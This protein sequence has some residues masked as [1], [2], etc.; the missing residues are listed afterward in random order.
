M[1]DHVEPFVIRR[2][3]V[4]ARIEDRGSAGKFLVVEVGDRDGVTLVG[5]QIECKPG[6]SLEFDFIKLVLPINMRQL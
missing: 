4:L 5:Y 6:N 3:S 2:G 1:A